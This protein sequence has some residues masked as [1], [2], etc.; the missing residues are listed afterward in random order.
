MKIPNVVHDCPYILSKRISMRHLTT[1]IK[2]NIK[3]EICQGNINYQNA[4]A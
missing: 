4:L 3:Y 1:K 2:K